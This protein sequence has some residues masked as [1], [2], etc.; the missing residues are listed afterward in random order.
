MKMILALEYKEW[1][2]TRWFLLI[3]LLAGGGT[4]A[5]CMLLAFRAMS[6]RGVGHIWEV[7]ISRDVVFVDMLMWIPAVIGLGLAVVQFAPE[8][9]RKSLKLTLHLPERRLAMVMAMLAYGVVA[10]VLLSVVNYLIVWIS[11]HGVLAP[12]LVKR[13]LMVMLP[14][15]IAGICAYLLT[16]WVVLEP[17]WRMRVCD[18]VIGLVVLSVF[19]LGNHPTSYNG[20]WP[21]LAVYT[22]CVA[23]LPWLAVNRFM[24]GKQ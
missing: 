3:A 6:M 7:M 1:I 23:S 2:K 5:Y 19:Y 11:L 21:V 10:M 17:N 12:E 8:M 13:V 22:L 15:H 14:W 4:A 20:F 16:A 18:G 24:V 9:R